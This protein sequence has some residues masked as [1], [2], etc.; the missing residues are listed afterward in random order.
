MLTDMTIH[1]RFWSKVDKSG[2]CWLWTA[3]RDPQ[4]YGQFGVVKS[5]RWAYMDTHGPLPDHLELDHLCRTPACV[6]PEHLEL[7]THRENLRRGIGSVA[8][9]MAK[10]ICLN[11]HEFSEENTYL[12]PNGGRT[13]KRCRVDRVRRW[14]KNHPDRARAIWRE[15][16]RK[17]R[18]R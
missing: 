9:N 3:S 14:F 18:A 11:G 17:Q 6:N 8:E 2:S 12:T 10:T 13:C 15:N 4:G 1:T 16:K 7:V 5:H